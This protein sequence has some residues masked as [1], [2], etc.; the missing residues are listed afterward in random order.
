MTFEMLEEKVN[1]SAIDNRRPMEEKFRPFRTIEN[2]RNWR[3]IFRVLNLHQFIGLCVCVCVCV[4]VCL[5]LCL[6]LSVSVSVCLV[7]VCVGLV[8]L[9][10]LDWR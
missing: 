6:C 1:R 10:D 2:N 8:V 5:C 3:Y 9:F 4:C 7:L